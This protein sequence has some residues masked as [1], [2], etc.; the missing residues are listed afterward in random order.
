GE[1]N[2][3]SADEARHDAIMAEDEV[4]LDPTGSYPNI[5]LLFKQYPEVKSHI[6]EIEAMGG[7]ISGGNMTSIAEFNVFT[8]PDAA[9][10][11]YKSWVPIVTVGLDVTLKTLITPR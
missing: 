9:E 7:S 11:M 10:I 1:P 5:A 2:A 3:K 4:I 6:K 8:D